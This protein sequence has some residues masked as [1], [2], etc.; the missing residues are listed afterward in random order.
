MPADL[1]RVSTPETHMNYEFGTFAERLAHICM[2]HEI[3]SPKIVYE[4]SEPI[5]TG[6]L[7]EW[8]KAHKINMDW[9]FVGNPSAVLKAWSNGQRDKGEFRA[10]TAE[11]IQ[12]LIRDKGQ[13]TDTPK[14]LTPIYRLHQDWLHLSDKLDAIDAEFESGKLA[15]AGFEAANDPV[16]DERNGV[17]RAILAQPCQN[18]ADLRICVEL[19]AYYDFAVPRFNAA[20][21]AGAA[22]LAPEIRTIPAAHV[23]R[24]EVK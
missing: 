16:L 22:L 9:L 13:M 18:V 21:L 2:L 5:L 3:A 23:A 11:P 20:A 15:D 24:G 7:S 10:G 12:A 17:E 8:I 6:P 4:D 1:T 14:N 19:A